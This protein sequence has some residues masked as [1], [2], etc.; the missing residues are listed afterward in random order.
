MHVSRTETIYAHTVN[1]HLYM[2][3]SEWG[4]KEDKGVQA[5]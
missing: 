3:S 2:Y 4:T 5:L 1:R